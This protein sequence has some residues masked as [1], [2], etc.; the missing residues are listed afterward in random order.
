MNAIGRGWREKSMNL[1]LSFFLPKC[2]ENSVGP[3]DLLA[4][5]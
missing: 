2:I 1:P 3:L 4:S 5:K